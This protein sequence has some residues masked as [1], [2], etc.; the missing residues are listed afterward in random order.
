MTFWPEQWNFLIPNAPLL[1]LFIRGTLIYWFL[2]LLMRIAGRRLFA[3]LSMTDILVMLVLAVAVRDGITGPYQTVGDAA[4]SATVILA[5]DKVIDRLVF[6]FPALRGPLRHQPLLIIKD[7]ELL[8]ENARANLLT[9][10][11][12]MEQVRAKGLTSIAQVKEARME[13]SGEFSVIER[14]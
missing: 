1:E 13:P 14:G 5:W 9:R 2:V 4:I 11:E 10:T 8:T 12:I 7:G 6:Y 3:Q